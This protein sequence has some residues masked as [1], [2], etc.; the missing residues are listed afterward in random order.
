V[1]YDEDTIDHAWV[2]LEEAKKYDLISGIYDEILEVDT[3]LKK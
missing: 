1:K 3:I 2:T